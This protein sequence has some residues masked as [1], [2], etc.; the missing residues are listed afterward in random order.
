MG[1]GAYAEA[2]RSSEAKGQRRQRREGLEREFEIFAVSG[3]DQ[4]QAV[5][6]LR[7]S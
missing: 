7:E 3:A 1:V 6:V 5:A 2:A 4:V